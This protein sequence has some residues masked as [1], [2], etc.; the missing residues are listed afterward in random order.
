MCNIKVFAAAELCGCM[1]T[2]FSNVFLA[3]KSLD[4][5]VEA[6]R[7]SCQSYNTWSWSKW[8]I[9]TQVAKRL[10]VSDKSA[11]FICGQSRQTF[12]ES[13]LSN[14][15]IKLSI[16]MTLD[17][18]SVS[19]YIELLFNLQCTRLRSNFTPVYKIMTGTVRFSMRRI[20]SSML[21]RQNLTVNTLW[22]IV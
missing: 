19:W 15:Q 10:A 14:M 1:S 18:F 9:C 5:Y 2:Q 16:P 3:Y 22:K 20:L 17:E 12:R 21:L 11:Q 6:I 8:K 7:L 13:W 4:V